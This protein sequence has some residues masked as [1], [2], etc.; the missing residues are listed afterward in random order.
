MLGPSMT[1]A[2]E[3]DENVKPLQAAGSSL[4]VCKVEDDCNSCGSNSVRAHLHTIG[5]LFL[6][7]IQ[8]NKTE[9]YTNKKEHASFLNSV[10]LKHISSKD[11]QCIGAELNDFVCEK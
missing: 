11:L 2:A 8:E 4:N 9:T 3:E 1:Q 7:I 5:R 6:E 10:C